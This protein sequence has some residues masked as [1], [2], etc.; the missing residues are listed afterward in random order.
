MAPHQLVCSSTRLEIDSQK[1]LLQSLSA[2]LYLL[3]VLKSMPTYFQYPPFFKKKRKKEN[4]FQ[5][6]LHDTSFDQQ[7]KTQ[8]SDDWWTQTF[9]SIET[10]ITNPDILLRP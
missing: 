8:T 3:L 1:I 7:A 4:D 5:L 2:F 9:R 10:S 6:P